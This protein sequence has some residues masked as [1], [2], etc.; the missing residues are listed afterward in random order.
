[1]KSASW[2]SLR[3]RSFLAAM[4]GGA[5]TAAL[6]S[7]SKSENPPPGVFIPNVYAEED[8]F[9]YMTRTVGRFDE[10]LYRQLIGAANDY[11]E[12]DQAIGVAA[13]DE[14][15]RRNAR[16]LLANTKVMDL[17]ARPLLA[18]QQGTL[19]SQTTDP[20]ARRI[21]AGWTLGFLKSYL[22]GA[23]EDYIRQIMVGLHSDVIGCLV[24][25]MTNAE[26]VALSQKIWNPLPGS[27]V[28]SRGYMGAR[29]QPNSP[30]DNV[31]DIKW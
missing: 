23:S 20:A 27:K 1:M 8:V 7:C 9:G 21:S 6:P 28:G 13:A 31:D 16:H 25:L 30:T 5:A 3:R 15:S 17:T 18:D 12:G 29:I 22:L 10:A 14:G 2:F 24:K 4:L 26:L 11:K 19:I